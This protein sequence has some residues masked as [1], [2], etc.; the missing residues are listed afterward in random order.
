[1]NP[2]SLNIPSSKH[3]QQ[4]PLPPASFTLVIIEALDAANQPAGLRNRHA[5]IRHHLAVH[6]HQALLVRQVEMVRDGGMWLR[7]LAVK[8]VRREVREDDCGGMCIVC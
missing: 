5:A 6:E 8:L 1:M 4:L 3:A 7:E 2:E